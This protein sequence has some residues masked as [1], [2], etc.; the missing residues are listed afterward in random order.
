L[1]AGDAEGAGELEPREQILSMRHITYG[2]D[3]PTN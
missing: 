3:L 2:K 1:G